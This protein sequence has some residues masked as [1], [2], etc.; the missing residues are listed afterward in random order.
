MSNKIRVLIVDDEPLA[1]RGIGQLLETETDFIIA[2]EASNGREAISA[3]EKHAPDLIFLDIQMPLLDGFSVLEKIATENLPEIV[4][5]TAFDEHAIQ[6]FEAGAIDYV[7][8]PI[9]VERFQKTLERVRRRILRSENNPLENKIND[10]LNALKPAQ[11]EY[12]QR[13]S[14]KENER[15]RFLEVRQI[16]WISS[17]GNYVEIHL[18]GEKF[19]L[20]ET[21][22]GIEKKLNPKDFLRIRRSKIVQ[23][24]KIK[25]LQ[26]LFNGEFAIVLFDGTELTS[27][28]RYR[29]NLEAVLN[30]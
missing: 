12:L 11:D 24:S 30:F 7:L 22:D 10:L 2:G 15:I 8:K 9:N 5:V 25:E 17:N 3:I 6:A 13:I 29:K 16:D 23:I 4:F 18:T 19:I 14:I 27:S 1:R 20:R 21:M 26:T 28:R